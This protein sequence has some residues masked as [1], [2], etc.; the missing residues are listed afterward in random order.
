M[1]LHAL[2]RTATHMSV[3]VLT[4]GLNHASAPV[5]V[6]ERVSFP[7]DLVTPALAALRSAFSHGVRAAA[8][9]STCNRTDISCAADSGV[10]PELP[11]WLAE[12]NRLETGLLVPH[13]YQYQ[14]N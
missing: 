13:L 4:F 8:I 12:F 5:S 7:L 1:V 6:R 10:A 9:L 11:G 14:Q 2:S 3:D